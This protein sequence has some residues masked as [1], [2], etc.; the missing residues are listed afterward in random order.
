MI[1]TVNLRMAIQAGTECVEAGEKG[2]LVSSTVLIPVELAWIHGLYGETPCGI[3]MAERALETAIEKMP[4][5]KSAA[6]AVLIRLHL[7]MGN[8]D[9][10][11]KIANSEPLNPIMAVIRPRYLAIINLAYIELE[12]AK[13]KFQDALLHCDNL[14]DEISK[15]TLA[16]VDATV[17]A[18]FNARPISLT[19]ARTS[20]S[21]ANGK[22]E[23]KS[24]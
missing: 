5:W 15:L 9:T 8:V 12:L 13:N 3:E 6:L 1:R 19:S 10:A 24:M 4:E 11:E 22:S 21:G 2:G 16:R 20:I 17:P 7:L 23:P 18:F 14:L